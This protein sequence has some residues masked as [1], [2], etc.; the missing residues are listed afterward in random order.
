MINARWC[1]ALQRSL[2]KSLFPLENDS[3]AI[4]WGASIWHIWMPLFSPS[5][6]KIW[7]TWS[8]FCWQCLFV[9]VC[10]SDQSPA[11]LH[12]SSNSSHSKGKPTSSHFHIFILLQLLLYIVAL[13]VNPEKLGRLI[14]WWSIQCQYFGW[15]IFSVSLYSTI[16]SFNISV[17]TYSVSISIV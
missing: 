5:A 13:Q 11:K 15:N 4:S 12:S 7:W 16:F 8:G 9:W 6:V 10:T 14:K 17:G 1:S 3:T 2:V